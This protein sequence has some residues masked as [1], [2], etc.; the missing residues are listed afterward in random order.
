MKQSLTLKDNCLNNKE[1]TTWKFKVTKTLSMIWHISSDHTWSLWR[2]KTWSP[3]HQS[4]LESGSSKSNSC[5]CHAQ[6]CQNGRRISHSSCT[7][8]RK[9]QDFEEDPSAWSA[10]TPA[11]VVMLETKACWC[12]YTAFLDILPY[13]SCP[14]FAEQAWDQRLGLP[15]HVDYDD[16]FD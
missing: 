12:Q 2:V 8:K 5:R 1:I 3:W 15:L 4:S 16:S 7:W 9:Y 11:N 10:S 6:G 14:I 13:A